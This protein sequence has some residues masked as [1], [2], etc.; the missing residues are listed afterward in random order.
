M[1]RII[2]LFFIVLS[3]GFI[4]FF[5]CTPENIPSDDPNTDEITPDNDSIPDKD[6]IPGTDTIPEIVYPEDNFIAIGE[7]IINIESVVVENYSDYI[8]FFISSEEGI[9][10]TDDDALSGIEYISTIILPSFIGRDIDL[11]TELSTFTVNSTFEDLPFSTISSGVT[12]G[13][14]EGHLAIGKDGSLYTFSLT[15]TLEDGTKV[16]AAASVELENDN[17]AI[18]SNYYNFDGIEKPIRATFFGEQEG[19]KAIHLTAGDID[20]YDELQ[21]AVAYI[22]IY[23]TEDA[24]NTENIIDF[25]SYEGSLYVTYTDNYTGNVIGLEAGEGT[26][27]DNIIIEQDANDPYSFYIAMDITMPD[28]DQPLVLYYK[29][30]CK[31]FTVTP[32][33]ESE[34]IYNEE[35]STLNSLVI[36]MTDDVQCNVYLSEAQNITTVGA[37]QESNPVVISFPKEA[38]AEP[39]EVIVGFSTYKNEASISYDGQTYTYDNS[40]GTIEISFSDNLYTISFTNWSNLDGYYKGLGTMIE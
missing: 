35:V 38:I 14:K 36:D 1:R 39:F 15:M 13:I 10:D 32:A 24:F 18:N 6:T 19:L 30:T 22:S 33:P 7:K 21:I 9:T 12:D 3:L 34:L 2:N 16:V 11:M 20:Y 29:G 40:M 17:I 25:A 8:H 28:T 5:S 31:D 27:Q 4:T 37:M 26:A 23:C